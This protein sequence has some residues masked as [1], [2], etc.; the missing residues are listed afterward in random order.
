MR[1]C[2]NMLISV[3]RLSPAVTI[4]PMG[5]VTKDGHDNENAAE[6]RTTG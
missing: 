2:Q 3:V 4:R 6:G 5:S 1:T